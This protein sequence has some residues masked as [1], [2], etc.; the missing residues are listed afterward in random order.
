MRL[1]ITLL[2][3]IVLS[4]PALAQDGWYYDPVTPDLDNEGVV[5]NRAGD[6]LV[7][8]LYSHFESC[9]SA[10]TP[11]TVSPRPPERESCQPGSRPPTVSPPPPDPPGPVELS[12]DCGFP[13]WLT[14]LSTEYDPEQGLASGDII[15]SPNF[16]ED[17]GEAIR[18]GTFFMVLDPA[19]QTVGVDISWSQNPY[20]NECARIYREYPLVR[21]INPALTS[22]GW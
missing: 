3:G 19:S 11:P 9:F 6:G 10:D 17:E 15:F 20:F 14:G 8:S 5:L 7:F 22:P 4:M 1:I 13:F 18:I 2:A 16:V 12:C 21:L